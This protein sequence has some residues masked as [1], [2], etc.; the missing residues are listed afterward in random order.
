MQGRAHPR[1]DL[2]IEFAFQA[3]HLDLMFPGLARILFALVEKI[4]HLEQEHGAEKRKF[5]EHGQY[6]SPEDEAVA[7]IRIRGAAFVHALEIEHCG[8]RGK[9][10]GI[11]PRLRAAKAQELQN[12]RHNKDKQT[13]YP[14][15]AG[16][17]FL[18]TFRKREPLQRFRFIPH[19]SYEKQ[20]NKEQIPGAQGGYGERSVRN[21]ACEKRMPQEK[22]K[23]EYH[24][25][26]CRPG[27]AAAQI[28]DNRH[29]E[30]EHGENRDEREKEL[31]NHLPLRLCSSL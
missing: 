13:R 26:Q 25:P 17:V 1:H 31:L 15:T 20:E 19:H 18:D 10:G 5:D 14:E 21:G 3:V 28:A 29:I 30:R 6:P 24:D 4:C 16:I 9:G 8:D 2:M 11:A 27:T 23:G 22:R 7:E 12:S